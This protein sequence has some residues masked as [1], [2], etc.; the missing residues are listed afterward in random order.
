MMG[1]WVRPYG[2]LLIKK[3]AYRIKLERGSFVVL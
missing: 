2:I 3:E 1:S